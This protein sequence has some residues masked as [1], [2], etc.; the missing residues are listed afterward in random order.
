MLTKGQPKSEYR[1]L[2]YVIIWEKSIISLFEK[3]A[4]ENLL[5]IKIVV[6]DVP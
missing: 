3:F 2:G 6:P 5:K 1:F 4:A